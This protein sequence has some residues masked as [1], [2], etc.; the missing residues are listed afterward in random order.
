M[1]S[2]DHARNSPNTSLINFLDV[3]N[4]SLAAVA[5]AVILIVNSSFD[6][7]SCSSSFMTV[8][9]AM[10]SEI[11]FFTI[12]SCSST[13]S[14]DFVVSHLF[15]LSLATMIPVSPESLFTLSIADFKATRP[16][17][18]SSLAALHV[19]VLLFSMNCFS[20]FCF[21]F[22]QASPDYQ[23]ILSGMTRFII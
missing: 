14:I 1:R 20:V 11:C 6:I 10:M 9:L 12:F 16:F 17:V 19:W 18:Y 4:N 21:C 22:N 2:L 5:A 8:H 7:L 23:K 13:N 3:S 15:D